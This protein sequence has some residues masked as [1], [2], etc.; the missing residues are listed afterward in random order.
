M[1]ISGWGQLRIRRH[2]Q[3]L[4]TNKA[5]F[6]P[7]GQIIDNRR[8]RL[9]PIFNNLVDF[10]R[11]DRVCCCFS[12]ALK[13]ARLIQISHVDERRKLFFGQPN[14]PG[15]HCGRF[16]GYGFLFYRNGRFFTGE[17]GHLIV[18]RADNIGEPFDPLSRPL[19]FW[20]K[21]FNSILMS[22][23]ALCKRAA[24]TLDNGLI[25]VN[26]SAAAANV[27]LVAFHFFGDTPHELAARVNLQHLRPRQRTAS[28]NRLESFRNL[29]RVFGG[30]RLCFFVAAGNVNN[31][32]CIF[33]NL[34]T[35]LVMR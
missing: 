35:K 19:T 17:A 24:E 13:L 21:H 22:K 34:S 29:G 15:V 6:G 25:S 31:C 27:C 4:F 33:V 5:S 26:L 14:R 3:Q 30:Q 23:Q 28:V 1:G 8:I 9:G 32:Q 2:N 12:P 20:Q 7:V 10:Q 11:P 16:R 18:Q